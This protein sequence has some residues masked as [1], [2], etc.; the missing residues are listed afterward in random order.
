MKPGGAAINAKIKIR[1][2]YFVQTQEKAF[3][4]EENFCGSEIPLGLWRLGRPFLGEGRR[5]SPR[6]QPR[7]LFWGERK[8][9]PMKNLRVYARKGVKLAPN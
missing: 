2:S 7:R 9:T 5:L 8:K 3:D 1:K 6:S 4:I